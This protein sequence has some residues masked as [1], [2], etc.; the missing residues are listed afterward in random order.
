[1]APQRDGDGY[2]PI[3][4]DC[5]DTDSTVYPDATEPCDR[6]IP[7]EEADADG[8]FFMVCEGDYDDTDA[9][10]YPG[11]EE[12]CDG[13][14]NNCN[15]QTDEENATGCTIYYNDSDGDG[16]GVDGNI[17]CLFSA[18]DAYTATQGGDNCPDED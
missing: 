16:Y 8:D 3:D 9:T 7:I 5:D 11:A 14:D 17:K 1:M 13:I 10:V 12:F 2:R 15:S 4:G 6:T 18:E